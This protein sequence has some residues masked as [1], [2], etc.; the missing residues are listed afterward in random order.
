MNNGSGNKERN[1]TQLVGK[2]GLECTEGE[3]SESLTRVQL[4]LRGGPVSLCIPTL[5]DHRFRNKS[6]TRSEPNRPPVLI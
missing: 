1:L 5:I 6:S 2:P 3:H 4:K